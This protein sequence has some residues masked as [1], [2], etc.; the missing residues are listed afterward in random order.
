MAK[1]FRKG[2]HCKEEQTAEPH[3]CRLAGAIQ[4]LLEPAC[5]VR[6][7]L[8]LGGWVSKWLTV[9]WARWLHALPSHQLKT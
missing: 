1:G 4:L 7:Q 3:A 6:L 2:R 5:L 8:M 9:P